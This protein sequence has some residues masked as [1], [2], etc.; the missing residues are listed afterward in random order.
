M[1]VIHSQP[2]DHRAE[3]GDEVRGLPDLD[4]GG[5]DVLIVLLLIEFVTVG[6]QQFFDD[7]LI[8]RRQGLADLGAGVA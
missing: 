3:R 8:V 6:M 7:V 1:H 2:L 5:D 4:D